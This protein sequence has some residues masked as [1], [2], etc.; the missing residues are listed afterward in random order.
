MS[1]ARSRFLADL[2]DGCAADY[3]A[4]YH[5]RRGLYHES[6]L[7]GLLASLPEDRDTPILDAGCGPGI[8]AVE[9]ARRGH[10]A[11]DLLDISHRMVEIAAER[12]A[13]AAGCRGE[14]GTPRGPRRVVVEDICRMS[15]HA[16]GH[17]GLVLAL[18]GAP[19]LS[20]S[21]SRALQEL[22][23]VTRPGGQVLLSV[24]GRQAKAQRC[25]ASGDLAAASAILGGGRSQ[26]DQVHR[27]EPYPSEPCWSWELEAL[28]REAGLVPTRIRGCPILKAALPVGGDW[29]KELTWLLDAELMLALREPDAGDFI[30][31]LAVRR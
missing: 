2:N 10:T 5:A 14:P 30:E 9:L 28:C 27:C 7:H 22:A 19:G 8:W 23:R 18:G 17:Y 20:G 24:E 3:T 29:K 21:L 15:S 26:W 12:V 11:L 25:I 1:A 13:E 16:A 4:E 6:T 31:V